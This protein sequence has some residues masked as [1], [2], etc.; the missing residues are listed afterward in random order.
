MVDVP[1]GYSKEDLFTFRR[2]ASQ[3]YP[4]LV[5]VIDAYIKVADAAGSDVVMH[6]KNKP[7][8]SRPTNGQMHLF[9]LLRDRRL[10][11]YNSELSDFAGRILPNMKRYRFDKMSRGDIATRIIEYLE[12]LEPS[13]RT[14]LEASM[15]EAL[16]SGGSSKEADRKSFLSKW[17]KIIKGI[18]L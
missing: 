9:D 6:R 16:Q 11:P 17:E 13:T 5:P 7:R 8:L 12:N 1:L 15:R 3:E 4:S 14:R 18:E 2:I 10:F